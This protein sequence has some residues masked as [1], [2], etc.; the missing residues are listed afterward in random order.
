[1]K[2][3]SILDGLLENQRKVS[4]SP[5]ALLIVNEPKFHIRFSLIV[6]RALQ[7]LCNIVRKISHLLFAH[8]EL[9]LANVT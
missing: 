5:L 1:M 7:T 3:I 2:A 8:C 4:L 6:N 9:Y